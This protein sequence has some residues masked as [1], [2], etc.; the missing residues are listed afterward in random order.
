ME[1]LIPPANNHLIDA[2]SRKVKDRLLTQC[3]RVTL[4]R[5][6]VIY[7]PDT[8]YQYVYFPLSGM[9]SFNATDADHRPMSIELIG[10]EGMLG[11]AVVLGVCDARFQC[12]ALV[13]GEAMRI[14]VSRFRKTLLENFGLD[15]SIKHYISQL[16]NELGQSIVCVQYHSVEA[17]FARWLLEA[18]DQCPGEELHFT[19]VA[20]A[21]LMGVRRSGVSIAAH[22]FRS[23]SLISYARGKLLILNR[24]G[25]IEKS[26]D[27]YLAAA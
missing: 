23:Q 1:N 11:A 13:S 4:V 19:H 7:E 21:Q 22:N 20:I 9:S 18:S 3:V 17:R 2:L 26:C 8:P 15:K 27:C 24:K 5:G 16:M 6:T 25:L 14:S 10:R 12:I